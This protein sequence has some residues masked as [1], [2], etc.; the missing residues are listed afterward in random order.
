[1]FGPRAP[2]RCGLSRTTL[3][4]TTTRRARKRPAESL[5][6]PPS[7]P[8]RG[9]EATTFAPRP[10]ALK[11]PVLP[12]SRPLPDRTPEPIRRGSPPA[13]RTAIW[14]CLKNGCV[15]ALVRA[16]PF[17]DR[18]GLIRK[19]S[20]SSRAMTQR[21]T[22]ERGDT[23]TA[24][25]RSHH[26]AP[27]R[28]IANKQRDSPRGTLRAPSLTRLKFIRKMR[29]ATPAHLAQR[30]FEAVK[31]CKI[32]CADKPLRPEGVSERQFALS[33]RHS[34][35]S[36]ASQCLSPLSPNC[37]VAPRAPAQHQRS[38]AFHRSGV[39]GDGT[40]SME[41]AMVGDRRTVN[42]G[43]RMGVGSDGRPIEGAMEVHRGARS[44]CFRRFDAGP[45]STLTILPA[46]NNRS[47]A[48]RKASADTPFASGSPASSN[49]ALP[50]PVLGRMGRP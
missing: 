20:L 48:A 27:T 47:M 28:T 19:F 24:E 14:T 37:I 39:W 38:G 45:V 8:C 26:I 7:L 31:T 50:R 15:R 40:P 46:V 17:R 1:M 49:G 29:R 6:H 12:P 35:S 30:H 4:L 11:R 33:C 23:S 36:S 2:R 13:L 3:A 18:P 22:S 43:V 16:P 32:Q 10:R 9:S 44:I 5:C 21:M 25:P 34:E 41:G 42:R